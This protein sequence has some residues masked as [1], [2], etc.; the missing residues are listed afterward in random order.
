MKIRKITDENYP[1]AL[2]LLKLTFPG[3][4]YEAKLVENL[5]GNGKTIHDWVA[6]ERNKVIAYIAFSNAFAGSE[7]CGLH[8][9]PLAVAPQSQNQG[10]G[11]EL[12]RFSMRQKVIK[13]RTLFVLG[14]PKFYQRFGFE[15]CLMPDC[16]FTK[17][18][19]QFL[20]IRNSTTQQYIVGYEPEFKV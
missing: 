16:P 18:R 10:V 3:S 6:I 14:K 11:S 20:S 12:L 17:K 9:G 13:E 2:A 7:I 4:N 19:Q 8:L 15:P 1:K 5:H